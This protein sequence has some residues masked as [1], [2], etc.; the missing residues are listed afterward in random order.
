MVE[1]IDAKGQFSYWSHRTA[2]R[3]VNHGLRLDYFLA[4]DTL[5]PTKS[6]MMQN[7]SAPDIDGDTTSQ[8]ED[9]TRNRRIIINHPVNKT[10]WI[11][12]T[13]YL[14]DETIE[15]SDHCPLMLVLQLM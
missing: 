12:D 2:A 3:T 6:P 1:N 5:M 8:V 9:Q 4:S 11:Y 10:A 15:C 7:I 14:Q 13:Y